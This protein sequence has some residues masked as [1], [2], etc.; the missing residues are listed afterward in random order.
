MRTRKLAT[1]VG[2]L[3][4]PADFLFVPLVIRDSDELLPPL[5]SHLVRIQISQKLYL[6]RLD[7]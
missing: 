6:Y 7:H 1:E 5:K 2:T 4:A 3:Y